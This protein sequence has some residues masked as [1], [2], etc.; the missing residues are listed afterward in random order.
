MSESTRLDRIGDRLLWRYRHAADTVFLDGSTPWEVDDALVS[1]GFAHGP[2]EQEDQEGL[3]TA[4]RVP[5]KFDARL[6]KSR[7]YIPLYDRMIELGKLGRKTGAG[8]YRYPGGNGKVDDPIVADLANEEAHFGGITRTDYTPEDIQ[9]R[10]TLALITEAAQLWFEGVAS[11]SADIDTVA[12]QRLGFP[13]RRGG[14]VAY[15]DSLGIPRVVECVSALA[16][17]DPVSWPVAP[18]LERCALQGT[19]LADWQ[20]DPRALRF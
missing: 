13:A 5:S 11:E 20:R 14:V 7:R 9:K 4:V 8:W 17:E 2:Y 6:D 3:D 12:V 1:F 10:V 15:A 19:R 16:R 18:P